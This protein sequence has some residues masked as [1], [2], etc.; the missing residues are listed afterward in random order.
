MQLC[1]PSNTGTKIKQDT[2]DI[3]SETRRILHCFYEV[4]F[5]G[6]DSSKD[7]SLEMKIFMV[8]WTSQIE[9]EMLQG[10]TETI[11]TTWF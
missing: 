8:H 10:V 7:G 5:A 11:V 1:Y 9:A 6:A 4:F 3:K 2:A